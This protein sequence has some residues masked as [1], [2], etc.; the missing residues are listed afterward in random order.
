MPIV[1]YDILQYNI[2]Y[3][4]A[5]RDEYVEEE[6]HGDGDN[7]DKEEVHGDGDNMD[8]EEVH[9]DGDNMDV[10]EETEEEEGAE[11]FVHGHLDD[12]FSLFPRLRE[13]DFRFQNI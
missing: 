9:G 1:P 6:V 8:E 4:R 7:M 11:L 13:C 3:F 2:D 12:L 10:E 5:S